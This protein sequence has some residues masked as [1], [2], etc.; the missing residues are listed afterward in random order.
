MYSITPIV[1]NYQ[2]KNGES[3]IAIQVIY[4]RMKVYAETPIKILPEYFDKGLVIKHEQKKT[5][6]AVIKDISHGIETRLLEA[7][8]INAKLSKTDL[9]LIVKNKVEKKTTSITD[10]IYDQVNELKGKLTEGRLRH[11]NVIAGKVEKF[12]PGASFEQI[13]V[14]W[15]NSFE[16]WLRSKKLDGNTVLSNI[17]L[18]I[19]VL[20]KAAVAGLIKKEQFA[21]YK[22]PRYEQKMVEYLTEDEI[23][24]F[25]SLVKLIEKPSHKLS[26]YYYMLSCMTGY[27]ISDA[28]AF[29]YDTNM[30]DGKLV[31]RAKK[32]KTIVSTPIFPRL[33]E[34]LDYIKDKPLHLSEEK[35]RMYV[36]ELFKFAGIKKD[37]SFHSSRHSYAM[38]LIKKGLTL[39]EVA[40]LIGDSAL[41]AKVYAR[42]HNDDLSKKIMDKLGQNR[43]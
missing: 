3:K 37:I 10:F 40:E 35:V 13:N 23:E 2:N 27:R 19:G 18:L 33:Q 15:L 30:Q 4:N 21:G 24:K 11:Y 42:I 1:N 9:E 28:K 8:R 7:I 43:I 12:K 38:L 34:I 31:L 29:D 36:K 32:N 6:N 16:G 20:N 25:Y 39:D 14:A 17:N 22:R 41:I 26:G 5:Y